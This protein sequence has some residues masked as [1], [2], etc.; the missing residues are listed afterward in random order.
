M[1]S[2]TIVDVLTF[3]ALAG[4]AGTPV[5]GGLIWMLRALD[6][7]MERA[8]AAHDAALDR[9]LDDKLAPISQELRP[10]G[11]N[12][13][14]DRVEALRTS[15]EANSA[16]LLDEKRSMDERHGQNRRE[17]D[18]LRRSHVAIRHLLVDFLRRLRSDDGTGDSLKAVANDR[19]FEEL[20]RLDRD[21]EWR[22]GR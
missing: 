2:V 16:A 10:N 21:Y 6:K 19:I 15:V 18:E 22:R 4:A 1:N 17:I 12:S 5:V 3:L 13:L 8:A 20:E 14:Y 11:G 7:R 9:K